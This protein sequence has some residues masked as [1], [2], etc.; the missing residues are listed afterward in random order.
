MLARQYDPAIDLTEI[1]IVFAARLIRPLAGASEGERHAMPG[2]RDA[3][4]KLGWIL[5]MNFCAAIEGELDAIGRRHR[6]EFVR[7]RPAPGIA[8][9]QH[10]LAAGVKASARIRNLVDGQVRVG[11]PAE[12]LLVFLPEATSELQSGLDHGRVG[13][14]VDRRLHR[15]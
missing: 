11:N 4:F 12:Y 6:S 2:D 5:R 8:A 9:E 1:V 14:S 7:I 13:N 10:A 3:R 15:G